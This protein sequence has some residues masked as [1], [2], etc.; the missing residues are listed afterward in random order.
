MV[1]EKHKDAIGADVVDQV[2]K[3]LADLRAGN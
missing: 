1:Y 2:Q 3:A